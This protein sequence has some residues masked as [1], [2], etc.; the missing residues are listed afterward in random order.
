MMNGWGFDSTHS[1][2]A[3]NCTVDRSTEGVFIEK[4]SY[5]PIELMLYLNYEDISWCRS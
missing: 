5:S 1:S 3:R 4:S 2:L